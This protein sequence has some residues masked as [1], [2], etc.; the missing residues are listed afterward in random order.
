MHRKLKPKDDKAVFD[1][2]SVMQDLKHPNIV[3][4]IDF[5]VSPKS[6]HVVLELA[7]GGDVFVRLSKRTYYKESDA[8]ALAKNLMLAVDYIHT[9]GFVHR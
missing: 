9:K 2:V 7:R 8:R 5:D 3:N 6:F 1:E 4:L